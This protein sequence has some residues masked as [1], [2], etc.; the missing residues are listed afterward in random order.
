MG[1]A[2]QK[3]V[4]KALDMTF[5]A[6]DPPASGRS[7]GTEPPARPIGRRAPRISK[8]QLD[9]AAGGRDRPAERGA[10]ASTASGPEGPRRGEAVA[11]PDQHNDKD[12]RRRR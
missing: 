2:K 5:P 9:A 3:K 4:D 11:A 12:V 6:S 1:E 10:S 8:Q 7:T